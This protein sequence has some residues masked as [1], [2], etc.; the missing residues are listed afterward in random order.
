MPKVTRERSTWPPVAV[1]SKE[2]LMKVKIAGCYGPNIR[3][4]FNRRLTW[5]SSQDNIYCD[6]SNQQCKGGTKVRSPCFD[7]SD[8]YQSL[9][10]STARLLTTKAKHK[11][12]AGKPHHGGSGAVD[13]LRL[14]Y[15]ILRARAD[16]RA[17]EDR[18]TVARTPYS[19]MDGQ[20]KGDLSHSHPTSIIKS[21]LESHIDN[22]HMASSPRLQI[23]VE[24]P[25]SFNVTSTSISEAQ[26][27]V[28]QLSLLVA[29]LVENNEK[30]YQRMLA[31]SAHSESIGSIPP[32]LTDIA[33]DKGATTT[34]E[35]AH[36]VDGDGVLDEEESLVPVEKCQ[37]LVRNRTSPVPHE[38]ETSEAITNTIALAFEKDLKASRPYLRALRRCSI[39]T[40]SSSIAP[41]MGWSFFSGTSL[42]DISCL[43]VVNLPVVPLDLWNG[44]RYQLARSVPTSDTQ[45]C[46]ALQSDIPSRATLHQ[47]EYL[48]TNAVTIARIIEHRSHSGGYFG[49]GANRDSLHLG[50]GKLVL[51][52]M[53][54]STL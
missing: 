28:S 36:F 39:G 24:G 16:L 25:Y 6:I 4:C 1:D 53:I 47:R 43:S 30:M 11:S 17:L 35:N 18:R 40:L 9:P 19:E 13:S 45:S 27:S 51:L 37:E 41:S 21:I 52:G 10:A 33:T 42:A 8:G 14:R 31:K 38:A 50:C 44:D 7:R 20:R 26:A 22:S 34:F 23:L 12:I 54:S 29:R 46:R 49:L 5:C 2:S 3:R 48:S 32:H 15:D